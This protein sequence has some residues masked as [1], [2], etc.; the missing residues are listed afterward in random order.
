M[1]SDSV[2]SLGTEIQA[3]Q[4]D[5]CTPRSMVISLWD[6][7]IEGILACMPTWPVTAVMAERD[8][9]DQGHI[10]TGPAGNRG[11][12][13]A[14]LEGV[15]KSGPLVVGRKDDNL[16]LTGEAPEG[17]GMHNA[18]A[19]ALEASSLIIRLLGYRPIAR[20]LGKCGAGSQRGTL[21]LL[22]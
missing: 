2:Q 5:V 20:S 3:L 18:V 19:V 9:F 16:S 6:E 8:G 4:H 11:R 15:S 14:Y 12:H 21:V 17:G 22:P 10:D 7:Q 1:V 13:L